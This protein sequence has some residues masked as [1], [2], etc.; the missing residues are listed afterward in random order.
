MGE[1]ILC[2]QPLA[3]LP[4]YIDSASLNVYSLEELSYYI[5]NNL[6]LL[7]E[8]FMGEELCSWIEKEM[9]LAE[10]AERLRSICKNGG[11]LSD[12]VESVLQL[13]SYCKPERIRQL[14][15][16][17]TELETKSEYEHR[18]L[19]AD[20]Y[21]EN[22]RYPAAILEYR[23]LLEH[24]QEQSPALVGNVW[25]NLGKAYVG[26]FLYQEAVQCFRKAFELNQNQESLRECLYACR[27]CGDEQA[28]AE[29]A[30]QGGM[31]EKEQQW[32][33]RELEGKRRTGDLEQFEI[34]LEQ[35][36]EGDAAQEILRITEE[37]KD[38]YRKNCR[39]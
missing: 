12:F 33:D 17:L 24:V 13:S 31:T 28:F 22:K 34:R 37:W 2:S 9:Q 23:R 5:E 14:K 1:L 3:A 4:Y 21:V 10:E 26:I 35:L 6:Y 11:P 30:A 38:A 19:K 15:Q 36:F 29:I 7:E 25:H 8:D 39:V 27:C 18:K 20:R 32:I 16:M